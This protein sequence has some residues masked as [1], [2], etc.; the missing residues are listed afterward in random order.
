MPFSV[1]LQDR[2]TFFPLTF[3]E[4]ALCVALVLT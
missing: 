4:L 1:Q 2:T 3:L